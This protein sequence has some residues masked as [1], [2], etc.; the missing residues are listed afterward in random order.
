METCEK[1]RCDGSGRPLSQNLDSVSN[2]PAL[3]K[4]AVT[5][6][7]DAGSAVATLANAAQLAVKPQAALANA[8]TAGDAA[9]TVLSGA[10]LVNK[11]TAYTKPA[12]APAIPQKPPCL[13]IGDSCP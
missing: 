13:P 11:P 7:A 5:G 8:A 10:E 12:P 3:V 4:T 2:I 6:N 1:V 9:R